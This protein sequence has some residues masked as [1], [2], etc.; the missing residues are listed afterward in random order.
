V[1]LI[2]FHDRIFWKKNIL[3]SLIKIN[4]D[5]S[6]YL[7]GA[8]IPFKDGSEY[9]NTQHNYSY[10]LDFFGPRSLFH[11]LNRTSTYI[12]GKKLAKLLL[13]LLPNK[14]IKQN[15]EAITELSKDLMWRQK[16]SALTTVIND[17]K[18]NYNQ[19]IQWSKSNQK[20]YSIFSIILFYLFPFLFVVNS[21]L[22][23]LYTNDLF[24]YTVIIS[25]L[26]NLSILVS[27]LSKIKN[28]LLGS[29][30]IA[31]IIEYYSIVLKEIEGKSFQSEKLKAIQSIISS[32]DY[33][34]S[35]QIKKLSSLFSNLENIQNA[36]GAILFNGM[37]LN[38]IHTLIALL[39]WKKKYGLYI[40]N[41]IDVIGEF[42]TLNSLANLSFNNPSFIFPDLNENLSIEMENLGHP[43]IN[44]DKRVCNDVVLNQNN[45]T[46]LTGSNMSGKSTFLR[47]LGVN[48]VLA[49][50]GSAICSSKATIHPLQVLVSMRQADS[51]ADN[52]SY[53]FAEIKRLGSI[54][55]SLKKET[56]FV[57]LDEILRGTNSDDKQTGTIKFI[58]K[59]IEVNAIGMLA[60]HDLK[61]C[62]MT[63]AH[64]EKL[65][66]K[67]FEADIKNDN[68]T[69]DYKLRTG[70]CRNKSATFLMEK[71]KII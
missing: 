34:V 61:V 39:K 11:N 58:E 17:G 42:E 30:K 22:L 57:L 23:I 62:E 25:F 71:M 21:V 26:I 24:Y 49:G 36:V 5:E 54:L 28:E 43:L 66:N 53:F 10:D 35:V 68:L 18:E 48:M 65:V 55:D 3:K 69:F 37:F 7:T 31:K 56:C 46:I 40:K 1:F 15:Q 38:H 45:F 60:T 20:T 67:H 8:E 9:I 33:S 41:W 19:L 2:K 6:N 44:E 70:V 4:S 51:L 27:Q 52:E 32:H 29:I 13:T 12:G 14:E 50:M 64:S 47:T 63:K 59:I 16:F